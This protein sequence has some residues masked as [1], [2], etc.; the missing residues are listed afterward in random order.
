[1]TYD[2]CLYRDT[3]RKYD[4]DSICCTFLNKKCIYANHYKRMEELAKV[5]L[6]PKGIEGCLDDSTL[7]TLSQY[8]REIEGLG[9]DR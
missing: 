3:C 8:E 6:S 9:G 4:K 2:K 7:F 1:M 5:N